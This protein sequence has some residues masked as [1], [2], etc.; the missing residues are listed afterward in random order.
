MN[1][2][3]AKRI[4]VTGSNGQLG[5]ELRDLASDY[6]DLEFDFVDQSDFSFTDRSAIT[7]NLNTLQPSFIINCAAYTAVDSAEVE[8][9]LADEINHKAVEVIAK[10]CAEN[11]TRLIHISTDYV[12]DGTSRLPLTEAEPTNPINVY[13]ATKRD[14]ELRCM[15][16]CPDCVI[17][18][19]AWVYS[20]YGKNFV[21]TMIKLMN[22]RSELNVV[23]DQ[24]GSPTYALDLATAIMSIVSSKD[25]V[26]GIYHY[27]NKGEISW[28]QF[29]VDIKEL[30]D[31]DCTINGVTSNQYPTPAKRP[32][33]SL[34]DKSKIKLTYSINIPPYKDSLKNCLAKIKSKYK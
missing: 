26:S 13:G 29:A 22:E 1:N 12:F 5:S 9:E 30:M 25:W 7:T 24:I 28:Y 19:T 17:I 6:P 11:S 16:N 27:S 33:Y 4:L 32:N 34:L 31:S 23:N 10:W 15:E 18:R 14:G 20:S 2:S 21:K 3:Q 8:V